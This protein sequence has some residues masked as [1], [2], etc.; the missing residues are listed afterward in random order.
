MVAAAVCVAIA[1]QA[2]ASELVFADRETATA[3][4]G[5]AGDRV[6]LKFSATPTTA[7]GAEA[8]QTID[9][10]EQGDKP[11]KIVASSHNVNDPGASGRAATEERCGDHNPG[12]RKTVGY[13]GR[14]FI[15]AVRVCYDK[16]HERVK[17][18]YVKGYTVAP[19][20][21]F[22][23]LA[24]QM[25]DRTNCRD[26]M[27]WVECGPYEI[28]TGLAVGY[29]G[30][31]APKSI[32]GLGLTCRAV[33]RPPPSQRPALALAGDPVQ[34]A[35]LG[36]RN[37][38]KVTVTPSSS[39]VDTYD[40]RLDTIAWR[41]RYDHPCSITLKGETLGSPSHRS[42]NLQTDCGFFED[43]RSTRQVKSGD[44]AITGL[45]ICLNNERLKGIRIEASA[46]KIDGD[47][48]RIDEVKA[49]D[50]FTDEQANCGRNDWTEWVRCPAGKIAVGLE[51]R[52]SHLGGEGDIEGMGLICRR[53]VVQ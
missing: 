53:V 9:W 30:S 19:D 3:M 52:Y 28:A 17:G 11:C 29:S 20:G 34:T 26:W 48:V 42:D 1:G 15:T 21:T 18:I 24:W 13:S 35:L 49:R 43:T 47:A 12:S 25:E 4:S 38:V 16:D 33:V 22:S 27:K 36:R 7:A 14:G 23:N 51:L 2:A 31:S 45:K 5:R 10:Y 40:Y 44:E 46:L 37:S 6:V 32:V 41:E 50:A 8:L 39:T